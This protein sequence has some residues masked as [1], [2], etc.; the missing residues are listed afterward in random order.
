M[1]SSNVNNKGIYSNYLPMGVIFSNFSMHQNHL[2]S[3]LKHRFLGPSSRD[4]DLEGLTWDLRFCISREYLG[5]LILLVYGP[6][7]IGLGYGRNFLNIWFLF[8][9]L[10]GLSVLIILIIYVPVDSQYSGKVLTLIH[11]YTKT[12]W[13]GITVLFVKM[14]V[15]LINEGAKDTHINLKIVNL[16]SL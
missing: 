5:I 13:D 6:L 14:P 15:Q 11:M 8:W 12:S 7:W 2:Y 9:L 3:L 4:H 10:A 16:Y 1:C